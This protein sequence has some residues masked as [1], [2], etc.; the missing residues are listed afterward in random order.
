[1]TTRHLMIDL[2][3]LGAGPDAAIVE[4]G[5]CAFELG[6]R[7]DEG[8]LGGR[9]WSLYVDADDC[10]RRG[11]RID[12]AAVRWW[13]DQSALARQRIAHPPEPPQPLEEALGDLAAIVEGLGKLDGIWSHG[14]AFDQPVLAS[15]FR[16][17]GLLLPWKYWQ[18]FDTRTVFFLCEQLLGAKPPRPESGVKHSAGDDAIAQ[19]LWVQRAYAAL[20]ERGADPA[21]GLLTNGR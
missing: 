13:M 7:A 2:E 8:A 5:F 9:S 3:T 4:I 20:A 6:P 19:T 21:L 12:A 14:A 10:V 16:A 11:L 15:A 18:G 1:M 17:C